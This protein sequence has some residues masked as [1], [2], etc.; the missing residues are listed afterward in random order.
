MIFNERSFT[1]KNFFE[2]LLRM[3]VAFEMFMRSVENVKLRRVFNCLIF[4]FR[5]F[6]SSTM[7]NQFIRRRDEILSLLLAK[8]SKDNKIFLFLNCWSS[9]NRQKYLAMN[10]YFIDEAFELHEMLLTFEHVNESHT[11]VRL[12]FILH[13]ILKLH[14]I[15]NRI[16][17]IITDNARN[18]LTMHIELV[19]IMR[20]FLFENVETNLLDSSTQA[21]DMQKSNVQK[22]DMQKSNVKKV[23]CL[24]HVIQLALSNLLKKIRIR[25][26][27]DDFQIKWNENF[28]RRKIDAMKKNVSYTLAKIT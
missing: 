3:I 12:I 1:Q 18:N 8:F 25:F 11:K 4:D 14:N 16:C 2:Q 26:S 10:V 15:K 5:F 28:D 22:S 6:S 27:N 23:F 20:S 13:D 9:Y 24:A 19:R 21:F 17:A 7:K